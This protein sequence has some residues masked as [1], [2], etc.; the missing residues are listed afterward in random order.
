MR[1]FFPFPNKSHFSLTLAK[2]MAWIRV[3]VLA[4]Q[5]LNP[6]MLDKIT[7]KNLCF[8]RTGMM[9]EAAHTSLGHV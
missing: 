3:E 6:S 7:H 9:E 8:F 2:L 5:W 1:L 4:K